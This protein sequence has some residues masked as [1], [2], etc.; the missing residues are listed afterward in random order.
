MCSIEKLIQSVYLIVT[1]N[2]LIVVEEEGVILGAG[3]SVQLFLTVNSDRCSINR[4][5]G[6][7]FFYKLFKITTNAV[8]STAC[9]EL[10]DLVAGKAEYVG[11]G[12]HVVEHLIGCVAF[13]L[14]AEQELVFLIGVSSGVCF[15][16]FLQHLLVFLGA[17]DR[18]GY[19]LLLSAGSVRITAVGGTS[20]KRCSKHQ[21]SHD[22]RKNFELFHNFLLTWYFGFDK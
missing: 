2:R 11:T 18:Q 14:N 13:A 21:H 20:S 15:T 10:V 7:V 16:H 1:D 17:P 22:E 4:G 19:F 12:G 3:V 6:V 8:K 5:C 9:D